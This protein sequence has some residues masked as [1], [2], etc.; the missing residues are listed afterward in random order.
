MAVAE[1]LLP[2]DTDLGLHPDRR[3][4]V[5]APDFEGW[6]QEPDNP[7]ELIEGWVVPMSPGTLL[8]GQ[9]LLSLGTLL[10]PLVE[11]RG[12]VMSLD[13]RHRL[14][15]PPDTVVYPDLV[16]HCTPEVSYLPGT[17]TVG[18]VPELVIELLSEE[19]AERDRSPRG[20]KFRAYEMSGVREYYYAW[21]DGREASGFRLEE[22]RFVE[23]PADGDGFF[24]SR[25]LDAHLR[26][27]PAEL[28]D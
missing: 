25:L 16:I 13:A 23:V 1:K 15:Q 28:R 5:R 2:P 10:G 11:D 18:R 24:A 27:V 21:P 7:M 22:G 26:L 20:A 17:E 12:W 8:T 6:P 14:P 3:G 19:T 9:R 4:P